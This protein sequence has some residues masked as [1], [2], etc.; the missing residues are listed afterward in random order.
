[1]MKKVSLHIFCDELWKR[2]HLYYFRSS[3]YGSTFR[4]VNLDSSAVPEMIYKNPVN[5]KQ[6]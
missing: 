3:D 5:G 1:M 4:K 2:N 6:V